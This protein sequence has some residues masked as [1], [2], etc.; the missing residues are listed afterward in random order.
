MMIPIAMVKL[1]EADA[2]LGEPTRQQAIGRERSVAR[3]RAIGIQNA[4]RFLAYVDQV[5]NAAL[6]LESHL[7]LRDPREDFGIVNRV[8]ALLIERGDGV[9]RFA[10]QFTRDALGIV[11]VENRIAVGIELYA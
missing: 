3:V 4:L 11:D 5:G 1:D 6:H 2:A 9:D 10:L 8:V 7:I